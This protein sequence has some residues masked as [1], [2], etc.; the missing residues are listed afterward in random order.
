M[1]IEKLKLNVFDTIFYSKNY[2]KYDNNK[3]LALKH[4]TKIGLNDN[5]VVNKIQLKNRYKVSLYYS[6]LNI[7]YTKYKINNNV[8]FN[9][10]IRTSNRPLFFKNC[11]ESIKTQNFPGIVNIFVSYDNLLTKE[12]LDKYEN[13]N[14]IFVEK[15]Y[16][17]SFN[18]Y[19]NKLME[20]TNEGWILFLD[21]DDM[22]LNNN[23]L[24]II[25][26]F[27]NDENNLILWNFLRPDKIISPTKDIK[28]GEIDTTCFCFHSKYKTLS[29]WKSVSCGDFYFIKD[30][31]T[32]NKFNIEKINL[33]F[34]KTQFSDIVANYGKT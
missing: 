12:Y 8:I 25:S 21:D 26:S 27:I 18:L 28:K 10:L 32:K 15:K 6:I 30:L 24:S 1:D 16:K 2:L 3:S 13:I 19:C 5:N 31:T 34:T 33:T 14:K 20:Q 11:F 4:Y 9:I 22:Y 23:I 29:K 7:N 17:Y